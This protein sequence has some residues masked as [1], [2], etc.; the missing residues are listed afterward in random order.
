MSFAVSPAAVE[1]GKCVALSTETYDGA[2]VGETYGSV[3]LPNCY[4]NKMNT[5]TFIHYEL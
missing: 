2:S 1:L 3:P 5:E 4:I